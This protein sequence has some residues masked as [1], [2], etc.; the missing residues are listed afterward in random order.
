MKLI[1]KKKILNKNKIFKIKNSII[2]KNESKV[3]Y[4][5]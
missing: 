1:M 2:N 3:K 4:N 5:F